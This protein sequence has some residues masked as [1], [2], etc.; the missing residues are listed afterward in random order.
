MKIYVASSWRNAYQPAVVEFLRE[1]GHEVYDFRNPGL[2]A[3]GFQWRFVDPEWQSWTP[4]EYR[5]A[6]KHPA[7]EMGFG[8]DMEALRWCDACVLVQPAG[9]SSHL[10]LG[11]SVGAG[12]QTAILFPLEGFEEAGAVCPPVEPEL[13]AKMAGHIL[14]SKEE[15]VQWTLNL[16]ITLLL[17]HKTVAKE[18][19]SAGMRAL[20]F[21]DTMDCWCHVRITEKDQCEFMWPLEDGRE[22]V[23]ARALP[24]RDGCV[25]TPAHVWIRAAWSEMKAPFVPGSHLNE[26]VDRIWHTKAG[27]FSVEEC[28]EC[29]NPARFQQIKSDEGGI[30]CDSCELRTLRS[31]L[32]ELVNNS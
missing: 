30:V 17:H 15:L 24:L 16:R 23:W 11:W 9:T 20:A 1:H 26:K 25:T 8:L 18:F 14:L 2:D 28:P 31:K 5:R 19:T 4:E 7:A 29:G 21:K 10:E 32:K 12:K 13:M 27:V 22:G 6:L 3:Q